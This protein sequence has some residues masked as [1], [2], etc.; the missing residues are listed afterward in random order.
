ML[1]FAS[2]KSQDCA[3]VAITMSLAAWSLGIGS[4]YVSR[5]EETFVT[6]LRTY[7]SCEKA[8]F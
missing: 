3:S 1:L 6:K 7:Y 5:D 4:C 2:K 8:L